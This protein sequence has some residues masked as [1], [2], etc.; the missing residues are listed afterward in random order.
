M[1]CRRDRSEMPA[2]EYAVLAA[3]KAPHVWGL[4]LVRMPVIENGLIIV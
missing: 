3:W 4:L 2:C 1:P